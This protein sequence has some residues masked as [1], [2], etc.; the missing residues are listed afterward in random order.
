MATAE[1]TRAVWLQRL[2]T[3]LKVSAAALL[4][5]VVSYAVLYTRGM[6]E[7]RL[8]G[9]CYFFY[10]PVSDLRHGENLPYQHIVC[11][12]FFKPINRIHVSYFGG[13]DS[14]SGITWGLR[15]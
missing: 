15:R 7:V 9:G 4:V 2:R 8:Y 11:S 3:G 6:N 12:V 13:R 1:A 14:C 10:C 5:Y